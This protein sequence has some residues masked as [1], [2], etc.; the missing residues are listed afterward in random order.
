ME[1][2][3]NKLTTEEWNFLT[4]L[5]EITSMDSWFT[6]T[7]IEDG[8]KDAIYD[9]DNEKVIPLYDGLLDFAEG[10]VYDDLL[11]IPNGVEIWNGICDK[12]LGGIHKW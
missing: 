4:K 11:E 1:N 6:L 5:S 7:E 12:F 8:E 10:L 3:P 2:I 9:L